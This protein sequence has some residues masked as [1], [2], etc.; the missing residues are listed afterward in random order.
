MSDAAVEAKTGRTW[1]MWVK[2]LDGAKAHTWTHREIADHVHETYDVSG[3]WAQTVTVGYE[4]IKGLREIGQRRTGTYEAN[5]SRTVAV[6]VAKLYRAFS[7]ARTRAKWLTGVELTVR[8][9]TANRSIRMTWEDS[10]S[11]EVYFTSK[12]KDK[13]QVQVQ[14]RKL[15]SRK[16]ADAMKRYRGQRLDDLV[17]L[18]T[19]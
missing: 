16:A 6:P 4:R 7:D 19:K 5:K 1:A 12:G 11:V 13:S 9:A 14:H 3:W 17:T 8:T 15:P 18:L 10:S 2:A